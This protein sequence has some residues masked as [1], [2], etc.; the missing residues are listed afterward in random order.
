M[1]HKQTD[2][3]HFGWDFV[4]AIKVTQSSLPCSVL[5]ELATRIQ[6]QRGWKCNKDQNAMMILSVPFTPFSAVLHFD[7][8]DLILALPF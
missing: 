1:Q 4:P 2:F 8:A 6:M 3:G 7:L 5:K